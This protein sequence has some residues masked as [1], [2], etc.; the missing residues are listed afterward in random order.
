MSCSEEDNAP[1]DIDNQVEQDKSTEDQINA[2]NST[3][4][5]TD[6]SGSDPAVAEEFSRAVM[7]TNWAD[8]II[9]PSFEKFVLDLD[10]LVISGNQFTANPNQVSLAKLRE[11]W[12]NAY[13]SW[14]SVDM[15]DIGKA[16]EITLRNYLNVFPLDANGMTE[17]LLSGNYDLSSVNRQDEQGF[18]ALDYLLFGLSEDDDKIIDFYTEEVEGEHIKNFSL[19]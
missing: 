19:I 18:S 9:I 11:S 2:D 12:L 6:T 3:T 15:F 13:L 16:E 8:N 10:S 14:Q 1:L 7:L 17:S 4:D 5:S